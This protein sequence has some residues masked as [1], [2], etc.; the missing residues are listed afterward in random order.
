LTGHDR[1]DAGLDVVPRHPDS[2]ELRRFVVADVQSQPKKA[3]GNGLDSH[4][5]VR[6]IWI[7]TLESR[8]LLSVTAYPAINSVADLNSTTVSGFTVSQIRSAYG[9][10]GSGDGTGQTIAIVDAYNDPNIAN[11]LKTFDARFSLP[12][13]TLTVVS[14]SGSTTQLP[15]NDAAWSQEIAICWP[16][17]I[18]R[19]RRTACRSSR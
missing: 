9:F 2:E 17:W 4:R 13:T 12:D 7:D 16:V 14:S 19:A 11:D 3:H 1:S 6:P 15:R 5:N 18:T 10:T 8:Q